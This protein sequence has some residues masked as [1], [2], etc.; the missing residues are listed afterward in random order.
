MAKTSIPPWKKKQII[1]F[2]Q[3]NSILL[4]EGGNIRFDDNVLVILTLI[5]AAIK[6]VI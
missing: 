3:K 2:L 6:P 4:D 5:I 1:C